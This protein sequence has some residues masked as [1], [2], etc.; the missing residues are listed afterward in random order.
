MIAAS[1]VF[2]LGDLIYHAV[3]GI[4][5]HFLSC[6]FSFRRLLQVVAPGLAANCGALQ[7]A[8]RG[9]SL[10]FVARPFPF[11]LGAHVFAP[12]LASRFVGT[13]TEQADASHYGKLEGGFSSIQSH[14]RNRFLLVLLVGFKRFRARRNESIAQIM[15]DQIA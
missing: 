14:H 11:A 13:G 9:V 8:M 5:S 1:E 4:V 3:L 2:L 12:A 7:H 10:G 6:P 15:S